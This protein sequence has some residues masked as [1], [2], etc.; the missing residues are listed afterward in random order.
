MNMTPEHL[1]LALNHLPFLGAAFAIIPLLYGLVSK[2]RPALLAGLTIGAI[3]GWA[4]PFVMATGEAAYERYEEGP[5]AKFLDPG[6]EHYLE[7]HEERAHAWSKVMY[8]S[9][10]VATLGLFAAAYRE[11]WATPSAIAALIFSVASVLSGVWIAESGGKIRRPDF[12]S[13]TPAHAEKSQG[14][15][16]ERDD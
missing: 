11:R 12:R 16:H 14:D 3:A 6:A 1:H 7:I 4:T 8:A 13:G 10:L 5:I 2:S 9:A 15:D